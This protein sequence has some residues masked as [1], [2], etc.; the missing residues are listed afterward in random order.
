MVIVTTGGGFDMDEI[1]ELLVASF[2][3]FENALPPNP[4]GVARLEAA[5][6][7]V[8][9]P[10]ESTAVAP[11]PAIAHVVSGKTYVLEPNPST[12]ESFSLTFDGSSEAVFSFEAGALSLATSFAGLDG[13]YRFTTGPDGRP[14]G[15]RGS[16]TDD[17]TFLLEYDGITNNDHSFL[18]F[19]FEG[20]QVEVKVQETAHEASEPFVGR[21][22]GS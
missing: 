4:E 18:R 19:R 1:D 5:V 15:F 13:T 3:D 20:D 9:R 22:L 14:V 11:L 12:L 2:V 16:W 8:A 10:P 21:L 17:R 6:S 7:A